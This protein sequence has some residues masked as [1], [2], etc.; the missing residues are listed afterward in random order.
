ME[1]KMYKNSYP[2]INDT[3]FNGQLRLINKE[4]SNAYSLMINSYWDNDPIECQEALSKIH[5]DLIVLR[6]KAK[7][8]KG[9]YCVA[10]TSSPSK[11]IDMREPIK[12]YSYGDF[13]EGE[14][15]DQND[16]EFY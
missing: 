10:N 15:I 1:N 14:L 13:F 16:Y 8:A 4:I 12:S 6:D 2:W 5:R 3:D 9:D 11:P 7:S